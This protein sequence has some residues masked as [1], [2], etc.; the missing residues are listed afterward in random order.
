MKGI[1]EI[2]RMKDGSVTK[3]TVYL[4]AQIKEH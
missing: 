1:S 2:Y 3:R 4:R